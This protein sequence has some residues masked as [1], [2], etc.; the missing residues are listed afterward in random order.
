ME[1]MAI[2]KDGNQ[3]VNL[4]FFKILYSSTIHNTVHRRNFKFFF[5]IMHTGGSKK[6]EAAH[7]G[8]EKL[9]FNLMLSLQLLFL[10]MIM[11]LL[12]LA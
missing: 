4:E 1:Y 7:S 2:Y 6:L 9:I 12:V 10:I 3:G 8:D 5:I 11:S